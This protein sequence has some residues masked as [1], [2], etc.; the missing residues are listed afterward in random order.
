MSGFLLIFLQLGVSTPFLVVQM[1]DAK[2]C[3][4][5]QSLIRPHLDHDIE[6]RCYDLQKQGWN[7]DEN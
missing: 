3:H 4:L 2:S 1:A 6:V 5:N 7:W